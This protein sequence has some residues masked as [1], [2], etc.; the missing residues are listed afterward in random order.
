MKKIGNLIK[1]PTRVG[2]KKLSL[3][4]I[5]TYEIDIKII[6]ELEH[7][8]KEAIKRALLVSKD[9]EIELNIFRIINELILFCSSYLL[10]GLNGSIKVFQQEKKSN[11]EQ[12]V[13][14]STPSEGNIEDQTQLSKEDKEKQKTEDLLKSIETLFTDINY[15]VIMMEILYDHIETVLEHLEKNLYLKLKCIKMKNTLFNDLEEMISNALGELFR[16]IVQR[17]EQLLVDNFD[18]DTYKKELDGVMRES[19]YIKV[20]LNFLKK[21]Y[22]IVNRSLQDENKKDFFT[23]IG[24]NFFRKYL[25]FLMDKA[26]FAK[27]GG[28]FF[29]SDLKGLLSFFE[30]FKSEQINKSFMTLKNLSGILYVSEDNVEFVC[31]KLLEEGVPMEYIIKFVKMRGNYK[32]I[33]QHFSPNTQFNF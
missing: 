2:S 33:I 22:F 21:I 20:T 24:Q 10:D 8:N 12:P 16:K 4:I 7:A 32:K 3:K 31:D 23:R 18:K 9:G 6:R 30:Q 19:N 5:D 29:Q 14:P 28:I 25:K 1:K 11:D 15:V 13:T 26:K 27:D 17:C